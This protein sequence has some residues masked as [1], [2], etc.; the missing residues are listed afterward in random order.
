MNKNFQN[1]KGESDGMGFT[2]VL[3]V[4]FVAIIVSLALFTGGIASNVASVTNTQNHSTTNGDTSLTPTQHAVVNLDGKVVTDF[5]AINASSGSSIDA[6]NY[7]I[8]N[9]QIVLGELTATIN[10]TGEQADGSDVWNVSYTFEPDTYI[11]SA[12]GRSLATLIVVFSALAILV[13]AMSTTFRN[14]M[15]E[16]FGK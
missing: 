8:L 16:M 6:G 13:A 9:N 11:S 7:T 1:K 10:T 4:A 14:N 15:L 3:I 2:G 5:V 12:G